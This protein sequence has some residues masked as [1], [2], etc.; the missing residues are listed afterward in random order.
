M[1]SVFIKIFLLAAIFFTLIVSCGKKE[2]AQ[3]QSEMAENSAVA[4]YDTTAIDS[5]STG[6]TLTGLKTAFDTVRRTS[7]TDSSASRRM[8]D[9]KLAA[10]EKAKKDLEARKKEET[11][12]AEAEA[13]RKAAEQKKSAEEKSKQTEKQ[14][15]IPAVG[16]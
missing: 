4:P 9:A 8:A 3:N 11:K 10:E 2:T 15:E 14:I 12:K 16:D 1:I 5:F 13:K 7:A 6:A